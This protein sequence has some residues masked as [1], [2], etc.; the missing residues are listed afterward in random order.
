M[1]TVQPIRDEKKIEEMK[2]VLAPRDRLLFVIGINTGLRI[3]D[4]LKLKVGDV[5]GKD[6]MVITEQKT[7]KTR[8]IKLNNQIK[9]AVAEALPKNAKD[10]DYLFASRKSRGKKPITREQA[11]KVLNKAAEYVGLEEPIG[12]HT[13]RKT[14]GYHAYQKGVDIALLMEV[15]NHSSQHVTLRYI[16]ILQDDIDNVY[17]LVEL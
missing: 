13:L 8:R 9:K 4:I 6:F 2:E 7:G 17:D 16:G 15:F 3:S 1:N 5:R 10:D 14:F 12:T 11:Y